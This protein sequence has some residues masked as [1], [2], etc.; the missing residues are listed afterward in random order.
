MAWRKLSA[1]CVMHSVLQRTLKPTA[2]D[3]ALAHLSSDIFSK[4]GKKLHQQ[5]TNLSGPD[6]SIPS[7]LLQEFHGLLGTLHFMGRQTNQAAPAT[8]LSS[9]ERGTPAFPADRDARVTVAIGVFLAPVNTGARCRALLGGGKDR[10]W[11]VLARVWRK[12]VVH[13]AVVH[14][15]T[16]RFQHFQDN[17]RDRKHTTVTHPAPLLSCFRHVRGGARR[18]SPLAR[19]GGKESWHACQGDEPF[20][21]PVPGPFTRTQQSISI[22]PFLSPFSLTVSP[23]FG[24]S[25]LQIRTLHGILADRDGLSMLFLARCLF[26]IAPTTLLRSNGITL[27]RVRGLDPLCRRR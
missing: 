14:L 15:R 17:P 20:F 16:E 9:R 24:C 13:S 18:C 23:L 19:A 10:Q 5:R 26:L 6:S 25:Y 11:T 4:M 7:P 22:P 1:P 2:S 12:Q 8:A 21:E 27:L 3:Q